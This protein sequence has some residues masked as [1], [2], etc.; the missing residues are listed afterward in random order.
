MKEGFGT[1]L[2]L[3]DPDERPKLKIL[4]TPDCSGSTQNWSGL[5]QAWALHLSRIPDVDVIYFTN[6]NGELWEVEGDAATR[7]LIESV[8]VVLYHGDGDSDGLCRRYASYGATVL[9]CWTHTAPTTPTRVFGPKPT[10]RIRSTGWTGS[11]QRGPT[12][13]Q[14]VLSF[15]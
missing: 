11:P 14:G 9:A 13:G 8:D 4:V 5:G 15:V 3:E 2:L 6:F 7:K 12:A 10:G 1:V